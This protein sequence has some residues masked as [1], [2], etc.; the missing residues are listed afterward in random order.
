MAQLWGVVARMKTEFEVLATDPERKIILIMFNFAVML[1]VVA[2]GGSNFLIAALISV[3]MN[4]MNLP[5]GPERDQYDKRLAVLTL[6][7]NAYTS[8]FNLVGVCFLALAG[9]VVPLISQYDAM[10]PCNLHDEKCAQKQVG[11]HYTAQFF[12]FSMLGPLFFVWVYKRKLDA[13][14]LSR[15]LLLCLGCGFCFAWAQLLTAT[16]MGPELPS[17]TSAGASTIFYLLFVKVL[18]PLYD[19]T[20]NRRTSISE[21]QQKELDS[22]A[23]YL[24][25]QSYH[26]RFMWTYPFLLLTFFL[27]ITNIFPEVY[28]LFSGGNDPTARRALDVMLLSTQTSCKSFTRRWP[29]LVHS[30]SLILYSALLT[31]FLVKFSQDEENI[32]ILQMIDLNQGSMMAG[33]TGKFG[34]FIEEPT[35]AKLTRLQAMNRGAMEDW[36]RLPNHEGFWPRYKLCVYRAFVDALNEAL[37]VTIAISSFASM[38]RVMS[39]FGMTQQMSA[40]IVRSISGNPKIYGVIAPM[41]GALGAALTGSTTT[42][43]FLFAR[44]QVQTAFDLGLVVGGPN[45]QGNIWAVLAAQVLGTTAGELIA[46]QNAV[47]AVIVTRRKFTD[48]SVI[49][50]LLPFT[51]TLWLGLCCVTGLVAVMITP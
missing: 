19:R 5:E 14:F 40:A 26:E 17:L 1:A 34:E 8:A 16:Y 11:L 7:G 29:W 12:S 51:F 42:S 45:P 2:P 9:D 21:E 28:R 46:P 44:L 15:N 3:S 10:H 31:P 18:E 4:F 47:F 30:G 22:Q 33:S 27:G 36:L 49:R 23:M 24:N 43:N 35:K 20:F 38:A 13:H 37:P 48:G 32:E 39:G 25:R 50:E 41:L 6:A